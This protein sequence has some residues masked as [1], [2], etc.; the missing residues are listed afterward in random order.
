MNGCPGRPGHYVETLSIHTTITLSFLQLFGKRGGTGGTTNHFQ[1]MDLQVNRI[2]EIRLADDGLIV[3]DEHGL[4]KL[5]SRKECLRAMFPHLSE[6][7]DL[8]NERI[9]LRVT[10][11]LHYRGRVI[12]PFYEEESE[13]LMFAF[14]HEKIAQKFFVLENAIDFI[15]ESLA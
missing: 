8:E 13:E 14:V 1:N 4:Q 2:N 5:M 11:A 10:P 3:R 9:D 15:D 7:L 12:T 6:L